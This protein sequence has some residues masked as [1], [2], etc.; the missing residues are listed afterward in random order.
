MTARLVLEI[1]EGPGAGTQIPVEGPLGIGR[2]PGASVVLDDHLV[3][4]RHARIERADDSV[5]VED[6]DSRNG[7][8]VNG[9]EVHGSTPITPGDHLL[10][11]ITV[12]ALRTDKEVQ[13][14]PSAVMP[15]PPPLAAEAHP[16]NVNIGVR[17][18]PL[19]A[20]DPLLDV[21][22]KRRANLAPLA[23][24]LLVALVAAVFLTYR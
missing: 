10:V 18:E 24:F 12:L 4:R 6:L 7:T 11:G 17:R 20:L 5:S 3:S 21:K 15:I 8:F 2:G 1:V 9:H 23:A 13:E 22:V 14:R 16:P 19:T